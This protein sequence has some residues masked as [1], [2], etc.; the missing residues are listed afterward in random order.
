LVWGWIQVDSIQFIQF[1][2]FTSKSN[3]IQFNS[4]QSN[5]IK[6]INLNLNQDQI[7]HFNSVNQL[8][9]VCAEFIQNIFK[10]SN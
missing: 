9:P 5:Q 6:P 3:Q 4:V 2:Q 1:R 7:N 8:S 10:I